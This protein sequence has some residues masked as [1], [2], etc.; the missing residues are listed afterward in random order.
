MCY[1]IA[2]KFSFP[3]ELQLISNLEVMLSMDSGNGHL[4]AMFGVDVITLW[5]QHILMQGLLP[6]DKPKINNYYP[7]QKNIPCYQLLYMETKSK[8]L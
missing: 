2:G 1:S 6:M 8:R 4:A 3:E 7:I 5:G